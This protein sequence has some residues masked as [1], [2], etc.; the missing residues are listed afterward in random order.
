MPLLCRRDGHVYL[1][2]VFCPLWD[3]LC[4][5]VELLHLLDITRYV[6][7]YVHIFH[8]FSQKITLT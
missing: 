7:L 8:G 2:A 6:L 4:Q 5:Q 3:L 1:R